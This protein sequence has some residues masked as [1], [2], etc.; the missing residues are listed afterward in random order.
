MLFLGG[1]FIYAAKD[2]PSP[3]KFAE[4]QVAESTK[5]FD[6]TGTVLLY[7]IHGEEKRTVI[8]SQDIPDTVKKATVAV[9]DDNFYHHIGIEPKAMLRAA[10]AN[11][12]RYSIRQGGSTI[13]QQLIGN[14]LTNRRERTIFRKVKDIILAIELERKYSKDEILTFYLNQIPYGANAYGIEAA[15]QTYFGTSARTMSLAQTASLVALPKA[16][17]RY[18]PYGSHLDELLQRKDFVLKRM[19]TLGYI[20]KEQEEAAKNEELV[21]AP[22][23]QNI[24]AP[25]FVFHVREILESLYGDRYLEEGGLHIVTSLDWDL[26]QKAEELVK[27][28][29]LK[30]EKQY[31]A[32]NAALVAI[33]PGTGDVLA[34]VGSRDYFDPEIDGNV[35]VATRLRQPG[36]SFKP[37]AY[38]TAFAKGFTP[39]TVLFDL[40]TNFGSDGAKEY[41]PRNY[42]NKFRGPVTMRQALAQSLNI[43]SVKTL[44]LAGVEQTIQM[45]ESMGITTLS[46]RGRFGL[47]LVLGGGE[48]TLLQETGAYATFAADGI[49]HEIRPILSI[50]DISGDILRAYTSEERRVITEQSSRQVTD[51]LSD[52]EARAP[53]FGAESALYLGPDIKAAAKTGT[54]QDNRDAWVL[55]YTTGLAAGVWVG[56]NDNSSMS[57]KGAGISAAGPLWN[58]FMKFAARTY[59]AEDFPAPDTAPAGKAV[60]DGKLGGE[61]IVPIDK[62]S[63]KRATEFTPKHLIEQRAYPQVHTILAFVDKNDP[64][65]PIPQNPEEDS[66]YW[67]WEHTIEQWVLT[68]N[69][70]GGHYNEL[71]PESYDDIHTESSIPRVMLRAPYAGEI[72]RSR[73]VHIAADVASFRPVTRVE[74]YFDS[75]F[76]S[77]DFTSPYTYTYILPQRITG[78]LHTFSVRVYD[79][80]ENMAKDTRE[81]TIDPS[82]GVTIENPEPS[83]ISAE[84]PLPSVFQE[85]SPDI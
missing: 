44:Y 74:F 62:L 31:K 71:P 7:D 53:V 83:D 55:G 8:A 46:D 32:E 5:I 4:R 36:S 58:E 72:I 2:L 10:W 41:V 12:R 3:G 27:K 14:T 13:T 38:A 42:D 43:P 79:D 40:E 19:Q 52:N 17:T 59:A 21:F 64:R 28:H 78:A 80:V 81:V 25:H 22:N 9:E 63:G 68:E 16:P 50:V 73:A 15:A 24:L 30:N 65:G 54:T 6:R 1:F 57:E 18:S 61:A 70:Q 33:D 77:S 39:N 69:A 66:Q 23:R 85:L 84:T 26:Q 51:I 67:N 34:M 49:F 45:A 11:V 48:L 37:F 76:I 35:N 29:A 60:L 47:S 20:T 75:L 56:N 82:S